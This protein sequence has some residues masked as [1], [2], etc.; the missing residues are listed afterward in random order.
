MYLQH[1]LDAMS[2][3]TWQLKSKAQ[4]T[5][6][7][8]SDENDAMSDATQSLLHA[9]LASIDLTPPPVLT[10]ESLKKQMAMTQPRLLFIL[11]SRAAHAL[12]KCD[13]PVEDLRGKVHIFANIPTVI[14]YHPKDLLQNPK[15][16]REVYEDLC[17][18]QHILV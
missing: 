9:M 3:Q 5:F 4:V 7:L 16:K 13:T 2:I 6:L 1:Y 14:T 11:G 17:M 15:N 18:M 8:V 12:L 10:S